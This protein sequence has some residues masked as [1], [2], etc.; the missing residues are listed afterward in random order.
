MYLELFCGHIGW[1]E[2]GHHKI[3]VWQGVH[4][5]DEVPDVLQNRWTAFICPVIDDAEKI[6][7]IAEIG[8]SPRKANRRSSGLVVED[9]LLR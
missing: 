9:D 6:G 3:V 5:T 8:S 4:E 7:S 2:A 1:N